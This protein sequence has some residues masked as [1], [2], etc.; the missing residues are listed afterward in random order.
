MSEQFLDEMAKAT[1][2]LRHA[3][4]IVTHIANA[5]STIGLPAA[6]DLHHAVTLINEGADEAQNA[7]FGMIS[8]DLKQ[9]QQS[10]ANMLNAALAAA[11]KMG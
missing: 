3:E 11:T 7:M 6:V 2:K 9:A 4:S 8:H 1:K 10:S 5:L